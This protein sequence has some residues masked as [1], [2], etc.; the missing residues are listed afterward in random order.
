M[1]GHT[2]AALSRDFVNYI[3]TDPKVKDLIEWSKDMRIPDEMYIL[4]KS[5]ILR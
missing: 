5:A 1:K 4:I 3:L 2:N